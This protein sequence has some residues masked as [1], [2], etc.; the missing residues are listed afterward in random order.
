MTATGSAAKT[1]TIG[2]RGSQLALWQ[3]RYVASQLEQRGIGSHIE[4]IKTMGDSRETASL[5][6]AGGKGLF[7]K[8]IEDALLTG[9]IDLDVHSL[10]DL[11]TDTPRGL[12]IAA[13]PKREDPRDAIVGGLFNNLP[14][15]ARVGTSSERRKAQLLRL[16][17]DLQIEPIRGNVDT[18]LRKLK[19]RQYDAVVLAVAGLRRLGLEH[20]VAEIFPPEQVCPAAGQG[21]LAIETRENDPVREICAALNDEATSQAVACERAALRALGGGCQLP[22][23]AFAEIVERVLRLTAV[24]ISQDGTRYLRESGEGSPDHPDEIG[25]AVAD[26]LLRRGARTILSEIR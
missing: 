14:K 16:R 24:V 20:E 6:Q 5:V 1:L 21:A 22:V 3:A 2:S 19:E 13:T 18:R 11:P 7:T 25:R 9:A 15:H 17:P 8:E 23:G 10:K 12:A 4:V 26:E